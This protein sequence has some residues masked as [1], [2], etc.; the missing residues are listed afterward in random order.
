M[1]P[2]RITCGTIETESQAVQA[3]KRRDSRAKD[4][5]FAVLKMEYDCVLRLHRQGIGWDFIALDNK[6]LRVS[7][8]RV[9]LDAKSAPSPKAPAC[10]DKAQV[11]LYK[12]EN[13]SPIRIN[14]K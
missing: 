2:K 6:K 4:R 14:V 13:R 5:A 7:V 3:L 1:T 9:D 10:A 11:W 12:R 8:V